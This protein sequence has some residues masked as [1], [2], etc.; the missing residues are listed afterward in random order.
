MAVSYHPFHFKTHP[1]NLVANISVAAGLSISLILGQSFYTGV[2]AQPYGSRLGAAV[3]VNTPSQHIKRLPFGQVLQG[4]LTKNSWYNDGKASGKIY[5]TQSRWAKQGNRYASQYKLDAAESAY[6]NALKQNPNDAAAHHGLGWVT[7]LRTTSSNGEIRGQVEQEYDKAVQHML[8]A[9]RLEP[10]FV[11]A[12]LTLSRIYLEQNQ[13]LEDAKYY[14]AKAY[15]LQ[16]QRSDVLTMIGRLLLNEG[17]VQGSI[18]FLSRAKTINP[19]DHAAYYWLGKAYA[20]NHDFNQALQTLNTAVWL[21]PNNAPAYH[22]M[23]Q[24]YHQQGNQAA[25]VSSYKRALLI[26]PEYLDASLDLSNLYRSRQD[27]PQALSTL[28]SAYHSIL[29]PWQ[30]ETQQMALNIADMSLENHQPSVAE[31]YYNEIL[32]KNPNHTEAQKGL[33]KVRVLKSKLDLQLANGYGGDLMTASNSIENLNQALT[34]HRGNIDAKLMQ[35]KLIGHSRTLS[36]LSPEETQAALEDLSYSANDSLAQG[37]LWTARFDA[38]RAERSF[39][40]A[41]RSAEAPDDRIRIGDM[42]LTLGQP[43]F[44]LKAFT[45]LLNHPQP[46]IQRAARQGQHLAQQQK[47]KAQ[48]VLL[49]LEA[50][51]Y[52]HK[53]PLTEAALL[54]ALQADQRSPEAHWLLGEYYRKHDNYVAAIRHYHVFKTLAPF[55]PKAKYANK[56][57]LKLS[58]TLHKISHHQPHQKNQKSG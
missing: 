32:Q 38:I 4:K 53:S 8:D 35:T 19:Y 29:K 21:F 43:D 7:Y 30:P 28:K 26:K 12:Q 34:Y 50:E 39:E 47:T 49:Q 11:T 22:T 51:H 18:D 14:T 1:L 58:R 24:I 36:E 54:S 13:R 5:T 45:P 2:E 20:T 31:Q 9:L 44:A 40:T 27:Y 3:Q 33:S 6:Q 17:D 42:L 16:P 48:H 52:N 56:Q 10:N 46:N 55:H 41:L 23:G 15:K 37:E 57:A 25:A